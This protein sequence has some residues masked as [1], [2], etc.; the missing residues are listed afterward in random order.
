VF[1]A[2]SGYKGPAFMLSPKSK[3]VV[4]DSVAFDGFKVG[5]A[6][7]NDALVLKYV[8]FNNCFAP[9]QTTYLFPNKQYVSGRLFGGMFKIDSLPK[10]IK[11]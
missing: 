2:D 6:T 10:A 1:K 3:Y 8:Q 7:H 9:V 5:I 4:L 11:K